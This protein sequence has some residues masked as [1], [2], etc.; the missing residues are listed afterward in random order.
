MPARSGHGRAG[1]DP[2]RG[3]GAAFGPSAGS[4]WGLSG[5]S[6]GS[7]WG[8][9]GHTDG[10]LGDTAPVSMPFSLHAER[11]PFLSDRW[12]A[13]PGWS[14]IFGINR[15]RPRRHGRRVRTPGLRQR[16]SAALKPLQSSQ[17]PGPACKKAAFH[18]RHSPARASDM[19]RVAQWS[20]EAS[21]KIASMA[22]SVRPKWW[23]I[24]WTRTWATK[25]ARATSPR[26]IHS[27]RIAR[28]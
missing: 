9:S 17:H 2:G 28:R 27:S 7:L 24:S 16:V 26:S 20:G 19:K 15:N 1:G 5:V 13:I 6:L 25:S 21:S 11:E 14:R 4:L 8:L 18:S 3:L 12:P 10:V 23:P 22:S